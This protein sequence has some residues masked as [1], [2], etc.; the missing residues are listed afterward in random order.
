MAAWHDDPA[1]W[2]GFREVI[3]HPGRVE[4]APA[5]V[6][7]VLALAGVEGPADVLDMPCGVGRHALA[8]AARGHRV[9]AV[10][11]DAGSLAVARGRPGAEAVRWVQADMRSFRSPPAFDLGLNLFTSLGYFDDPEDD[12]RVLRSFRDALRPGGRL[13]V[14]VLGLEALLLHYQSERVTELPGGRLVVEQV[15]PIEDW[16]RI[17]ARWTLVDGD[18]VR[19]GELVLRLF[20]AR[21]LK[22]MFLRTGFEDVRCYG[23]LD[24][25]PYDAQARRLVVVG[26][27]GA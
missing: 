7:Q 22:G 20:P 16:A 26:R 27:R 21:V 6:E 14:D 17:H 23:G 11:R 12:L 9:T 4:A 25:R 15:R 5:E 3:F 1:F 2:D 19:R 10:D 24:G 8:L 18:D 13:V